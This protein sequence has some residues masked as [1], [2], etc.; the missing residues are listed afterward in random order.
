MPLRSKVSMIVTVVTACLAT[1][2]VS[3]LHIRHVW[4]ELLGTTYA[5]TAAATLETSNRNIKNGIPSL[6]RD[7]TPFPRTPSME[8]RDWLQRV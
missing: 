2:L 8:L 1:L 4:V 6:K 7:R 3:D 5:R